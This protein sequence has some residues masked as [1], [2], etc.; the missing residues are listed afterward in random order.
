MVEMSIEVI[1][2]GFGRTGTLSL[3]YALEKLGFDR[4]Y[5][6]LEVQND[7]AHVQIWRDAAAGVEPDWHQ[8]FQGYKASVDWPSCNYWREQM[9][10]FPD[11]KVILSRRDSEMW[12]A[13]IMNTIWRVTQFGAEQQDPRARVG[14]DMAYE[15]IWDAVFDRR[16]DDKDHVIACYE[17]HNQ[18][19]ID[20]V[21]DDKL[22]VYEPGQGWQPVCEFLGVPI[23]DED[24]PRVNTT[25]EFTERWRQR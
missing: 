21:P 5:H 18:Q 24:Y 3:K 1:G 20:E 22:L 12:Y 11:A 7:P 4:C 16:M 13:S 23:P 2:A 15:V 14:A 6:M 25:E 19:V 17:A 10:A 8:L 9:A